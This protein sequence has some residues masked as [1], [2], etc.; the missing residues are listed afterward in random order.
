MTAV[1]IYTKEI[2]SLQKKHAE[3]GTFELSKIVFMSS[4]QK[5][6]FCRCKRETKSRWHRGM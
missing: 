6:L 1:Q 4:S 2:G 3:L 5:F